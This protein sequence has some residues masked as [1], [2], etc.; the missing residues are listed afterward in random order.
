MSIN[1]P[2]KV[3]NLFCTSVYSLL[4]PTFLNEVNKI[5]DRYIEETRNNN[6]VLN[7]IRK[8]YEFKN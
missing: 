5:S 1:L 6:H 4:M 3:D 8:M 2:L 7:L